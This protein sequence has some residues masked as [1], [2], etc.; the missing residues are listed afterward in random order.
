MNKLRIK[1]PSIGFW[2]TV[3]AQGIVALVFPRDYKK[4]VFGAWFGKQFTCN[5]R[6]F[7]E[8]CVKRGGFN[9]VWIGDSSLREK[10]LSIPGARFAAIGSISAYWHLL[11]SGFWAWNVQWRTKDTMRF[12]RCR[13]VVQLYM[14]HGYPDKNT[15]KKQFNGTGPVS[16]NVNVRGFKGRLYRFRDGLLD[17]LYG[18]RSWMS[19]S[20]RQGAAIA[21]ANTPEI[22]T[23]SMMVNFGT[24]RGDYFIHGAD[25]CKLKAQLR[26]KFAKL[27][28]IPID[29][30]WCLFVPTWRH[31]PQYLFSFTTSEHLEDYEA[32]LKSKNM[33]LIEKQHPL[34]LTSQ[35]II[36]GKRG[37]MVVV[38]GEQALK[39]DT[40]ELLMAC[41]RLIT[42][43]SSVYYD[44]VL[45]NRPVIHYTYDFDHFMNVDMGFNFDMREYGGG[46]FA[47]TEDE[48]LKFMSMPDVDL[49]ARRNVKTM[50][51]LEFEKGDSC[52]QYYDLVM[53]LSKERGYFVP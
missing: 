28:D 19:N 12:P 37:S 6:Y 23:P 24:P 13:R 38:S 31:D 44:F 11:T 4:I 35:N 20:S 41:D 29:K 30:K 40:Q 48:L 8:Y 16:N 32:V 14:R 10:V 3:C 46:P 51:Q 2:A 47:Y 45:M 9:C 42:D 5:S 43:Y 1:I 22:A 26:E 53:K 18:H 50:E 52:E 33:I 34:T 7:F 17:I 21:L 25:D 49:L 36:A 15:G 39:I 27:L